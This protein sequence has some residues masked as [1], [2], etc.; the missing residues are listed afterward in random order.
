MSVA[1]EVPCSAVTISVVDNITSRSVAVDWT[2][3]DKSELQSFSNHFDFEDHI[4]IFFATALDKFVGVSSRIEPNEA[5]R[6]FETCQAIYASFDNPS[7]SPVSIW[8]FEYV[9]TNRETGETNK[10]CF[11]AGDDRVSRLSSTNDEASFRI[12]VGLVPGEPF[13]LRFRPFTVII[14]PSALLNYRFGP[15]S[16]FRLINALDDTPDGEI[17]GFTVKSREDDRL[18]LEWVEPLVTNGIITRYLALARDHVNPPRSA[19]S[20]SPI[21]GKSANPTVTFSE[22][23]PD[24]TYEISV[25]AETV[26][27]SGPRFVTNV[28]TCGL[29]LIAETGDTC[30]SRRGFFL[31]KD[32]LPVSCNDFKESIETKDCEKRDLRIG[33]VRILPGYWRPSNDSLDIRVCPL[34]PTACLGG[35]AI[36]GGL[37]SPNYEG[38]MCSLC[39][40]GYFNN[41]GICEECGEPSIGSFGL[42]IAVVSTLV[43]IGV[44]AYFFGTR[45]TISKGV[46]ASLALRLQVLLPT[47]QIVATFSWTLGTAFPATYAEILKFLLFFSFD[48]S[49][50]VPALGCIYRSNYLVEL[51]VVSIL[52]II[53]F[54][55][56][57]LVYGYWHKLTKKDSDEDLIKRRK[58]R[59]F[60]VLI[61]A[62]FVVYTPV[63]SKIFRA[64]RPCDKFPDIGKSYMPEDYRIECSTGEYALVLTVAYS[65]MGVYCIGVPCFYFSILW[66]KR[67]EISD[68][69]YLIAL[70]DGRSA[71][72]E[73]RL[74]DLEEKHKAEQF[75]YRS[76]K[77]WWWELVEILRKIVLAGMIALVAPGTA[78][79]SLILML[80]ALGST[81]LYHHFMPFQEAN[82]LGLVAAYTIF[83]AA[84]ASLLVK[85]ADRFLD[86]VL[87]DVA[88]V[89][90]VCCPLLF[91]FLFTD[92]FI[93]AARKRCCI[94]TK[95]SL[96]RPLE[97]QRPVE[98]F[99]PVEKMM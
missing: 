68:Q 87:F 71:G 8:G 51:V 21:E 76:Y 55:I 73:A 66:P 77:Y 82:L 28:S 70:G 63:T 29:N 7:A 89:I 85:L 78:E 60:Q 53:V 67:Q 64:L 49:D 48:I 11:F 91:G 33:D 95:F 74:K 61:I 24:T 39:S 9:L 34:G 40:D 54:A 14:K 42:L 50:L 41:G 45:S 4:G 97:R 59:A 92:D 80:L 83:F 43:V 72:D 58:T 56:P 27:G 18:V 57:A 5:R 69:C 96:G 32:G 13:E 84:L 15:V 62:T 26:A 35:A 22:L 10:R 30:V 23:A 65:M 46:P 86:S 2:Y 36:S 88:L 1:D 6:L 81:V 47:Y 79:Q 93:Q 17:I 94:P 90:I 19:A 16:N 75:L 37:C 25:Y 12:L 38:P 20:V 31:D 44:I 52:P 99:H 98:S 3:P